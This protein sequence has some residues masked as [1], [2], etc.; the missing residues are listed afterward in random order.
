MPK[1]EDKFWYTSGSGRIEFQLTWEQAN[2]GYHQGQCDADIKEL[3][4]QD[5]ELIA[6]LAKLDPVVVREEL[7]EYGAWD[8]EELSNHQTNIERLLW[9][10][11][12]DVI[13][14]NFGK[15]E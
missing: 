14:E 3:T 8:D 1:A 2:K 15:E 9:L 5:A 12:G 6:T 13:D 7:S 10:A 11:C 4:T